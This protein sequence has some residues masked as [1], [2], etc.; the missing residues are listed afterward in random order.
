MIDERTLIVFKPDVIQRQIVGELITRFERKGFKIVGMKMVHPT[1]ELVGKHYEADEA[2]MTEV[3][4]KTI[5]FAK[6]RGED[7]GDE[8]ALEIGQ[9]VRLWNIEYLSCGPVIAAVV[10]GPNVIEGVRKII[11]R[12]NPIVADVGT[13]RSDY[14]P[15]S[16]LL[17]DIQGR[18]TRTM[19]HASD[20]PERASREISLWFDE[21]EICKYE[22]AI[23]KVLYDVGWSR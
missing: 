10:E 12:S 21:S 22:T 3:G 8:T 23:E 13:I 15:D 9:R 5:A 6:E 11:G 20:A 17:A 1:R 18:T 14:T 4:E 19:I 16:Y 7:V 2:Y